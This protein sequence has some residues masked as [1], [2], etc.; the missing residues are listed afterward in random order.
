MTNRRE[1]L[2]EAPVTALVGGLSEEIASAPHIDDQQSMIHWVPAP[3]FDVA[4]SA[5]RAFFDEI[6]VMM[7]PLAAFDP[8][9]GFAPPSTSTAPSENMLRHVAAKE[10]ER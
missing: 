7:H 9:R 3:C 10:P 4:I 5:R 8:E 2:L 6:R 1:E